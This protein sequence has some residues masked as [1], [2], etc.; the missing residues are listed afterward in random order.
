[1]KIIALFLLAA[2][3]IAPNPRPHFAMS[4]LKQTRFLFIRDVYFIGRVE[5]S[6]GLTTKNLGS[7]WYIFGGYF[8]KLLTGEKKV[9]YK[10]FINDKKIDTNLE[11]SK[12]TILPGK[13]LEANFNQ[14]L[15]FSPFCQN[16]VNFAV[17]CMK[18]MIDNGAFEIRLG[19]QC[20]LID[21]KVLSDGVEAD[22][23][24]VEPKDDS[25][26]VKKEE[27]SK[28]AKA[29]EDLKKVKPEEDSKT[30]KPEEVSKAVKFSKWTQMVKVNTEV[31]KEYPPFDISDVASE[32]TGIKED[33]KK[34]DTKP[35]TATG[36]KKEEPLKKP[37]EKTTIQ[38]PA[39]ESKTIV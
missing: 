24:V 31:G 15:D 21:E 36:E 28:A 20:D 26:P 23:K 39:E 14:Y 33:D 25:K 10:I 37:E 5:N 8:D 16:S 22:P 35:T 11:V 17:K 12:A 30:S 4:I 9:V 2:S 19:I 1:M 6:E 32:N 3:I 7:E 13:E 34:V 38:N 18:L 29:E 27:D